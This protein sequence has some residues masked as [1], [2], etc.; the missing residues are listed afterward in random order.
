M[1]QATR[2]NVAMVEQSTLA[3][4]MLQREAEEPGRL[5]GRFTVDGRGNDPVPHQHLR[6]VA[7]AFGG[8][9]QRRAG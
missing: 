1:D 2:Q 8:G 3:T 9:R 6:A 4:S 7:D 5:I